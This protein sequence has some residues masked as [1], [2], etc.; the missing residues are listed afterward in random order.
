MQGNFCTAAA[1]SN[2]PQTVWPFEQAFHWVPAF[3]YQAHSLL[4]SGILDR[5]IKD[6]SDLH[7]FSSV[8]IQKGIKPEWEVQNVS[9]RENRL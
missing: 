7:L 8:F 6:R 3:P 4:R 5:M 9:K 2:G 1:G